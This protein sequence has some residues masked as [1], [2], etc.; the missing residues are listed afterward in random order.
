MGTD[1]CVA[2]DMAAC[3]PRVRNE[4]RS[5]SVFAIILPCANDVPHFTTG[6]AAGSPHGLMSCFAPAGWGL[7]QWAC[8]PRRPRRPLC[9]TRPTMSGSANEAAMR[10]RSGLS[11]QKRTFRPLSMRM[12]EALPCCRPDN[13]KSRR[14]YCFLRIPVSCWEDA[15]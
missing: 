9:G 6:S 5:L 1:P 7:Q 4:G 3:E 10:M 11:G 12:W 14:P 2:F 8:S 15:G 13:M